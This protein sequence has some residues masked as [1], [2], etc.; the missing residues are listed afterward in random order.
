MR[1]ACDPDDTI[2]SAA[3]LE[4]GDADAG[5]DKWPIGVIGRIAL[6]VVDERERDEVEV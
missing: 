5:P 2:S 4:V 3:I 6:R 1:S